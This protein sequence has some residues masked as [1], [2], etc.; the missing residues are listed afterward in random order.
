MKIKATA[1]NNLKLQK[2]VN[3][4][5][6]TLSSKSLK[7]AKCLIISALR[8]YG[9]NTAFNVTLPPKVKKHKNIPSAPEVMKIIKG[10]PV[11]LPCLLAMWLSLRM[12][13]VRGLKF[14][15]L[16]NGVLHIQRSKLVVGGKDVVR[17]VNKTESSTRSIALPEYLVSLIESVPHKSDDEFIIKDG[18]YGLLGKYKR[19]MKSN[20]LDTRFHDLRAVNASVMLLLGIPDKYAMERGGWSTPSVLKSVYQH[21]FSDERKL[22]DKRIDDYFNSLIVDTTV[23]TQ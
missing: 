16:E 17:E 3:D 10:T 9:F 21:T 23:D 7:D 8:L 15:D 5:A 18:Y 11:E 13:E 4:E 20:G 1:L 6:K 22:V 12:S 19:L 14:K 2:A